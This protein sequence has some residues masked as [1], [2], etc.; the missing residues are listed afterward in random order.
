MHMHG[1]RNGYEWELNR[2]TLRRVHTRSGS[3]LPACLRNRRRR[4]MM[5]RQSAATAGSAA[6]SIPRFLSL[7]CRGPKHVGSYLLPSCLP[8]RLPVATP[9]IPFTSH[10][11]TQSMLISSPLLATIGLFSKAWTPKFNF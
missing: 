1:C 8:A 7:P 6:A 11:P 4:G 2:R 5:P 9:V 3:C 10:D